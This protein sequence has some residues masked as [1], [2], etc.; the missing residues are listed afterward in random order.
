MAR[1]FSLLISVFV[2]SCALLSSGQSS[3]KSESSPL[4]GSLPHI[5]GLIDS[6]DQ[7][8]FVDLL[9]ALS[10]YAK[11]E[12]EIKVFP[13]YRAALNVIEGTADFKIPSVRNTDE[14]TS[15][16]PFRFIS[17]KF[18]TVSFVIYSNI[19]KPIT[20]KMIQDALAK[21]EPFPYEFEGPANSGNPFGIPVP[22]SRSVALSL[23]KVQ[24]GRI[25]GFIWAQEDADKVIED[26]KLNKIHRAYWA[27]FD[28][29][30]I[31]AKNTQGD[32]ADAILSDAIRKFRASGQLKKFYEKIHLPYREWQPAQMDWPEQP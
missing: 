7:G 25:D 15:R 30:A 14:E 20:K 31:V 13:L 21:N 27:D 29:T 4:I 18:G 2:L 17:E 32:R 9:K 8:V 24:K 12:I 1:Y 10:A 16:L 22:A 5:P 11:E 19:K 6:P 28:D 3:A 26:L 23:K